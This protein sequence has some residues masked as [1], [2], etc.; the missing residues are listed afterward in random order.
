MGGVGLCRVTVKSWDT[1]LQYPLSFG[2][3]ESYVVL[4]KWNILGNKSA[5]VLYMSFKDNEILLIAGKSTCL[6]VKQAKLILSQI[7]ELFLFPSFSSL[8]F[9]PPAGCHLCRLAAPFLW[10]D[11]TGYVHCT[12]D[13]AQAPGKKKGWSKKEL[14]AIEL[15]NAQGRWRE[16]LLAQRAAI[17]SPCPS[18]NNH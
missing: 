7:L 14:R 6:L 17:K 8:S 2:T 15:Q 3:N 13:L 11:P 18:S 5:S 9:D 12:A 4:I 1:F 16:R 10:C